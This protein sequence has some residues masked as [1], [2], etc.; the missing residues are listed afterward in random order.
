ML[1][2]FS[3]LRGRKTP[4]SSRKSEVVATRSSSKPVIVLVAGAWHLPDA[5]HKVKPQL[6]TAGYEVYT[7]RS[8]TVVGPEPVN[9]SWRVDVAMI[10]DL[11]LPLFE[12][13]REVVIVGHSYGGVVATA[14][15]EGQTIL[16]RRLRGL[17]GG[18]SAVVYVTAFAFPQRGGCIA[19]AIGGKYPEWMIA[20]EPYKNIQFSMQVAL[21]L[22][23]FYSDLPEDEAAGWRAKLQHHSQ[24]SFEEPLGYCANDI[25]IPM[26]YLICEGD[27]TLPLELQESMVQGIAAMTTRRC[28]AGHSPFLS[29]PDRTTEVIIEAARNC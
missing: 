16:D 15:V 6:E 11:V 5:W 25:K 8:M 21:E 18:F 29:Q 22:E 13:G 24:R 19:S 10:H 17:S 7:P 4:D 27:K 26:T 12:Q 9:H 20:A 23:S 1:W 14:S 28:T 2:S 3:R